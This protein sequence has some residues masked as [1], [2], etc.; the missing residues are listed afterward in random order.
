MSYKQLPANA[1]ERGAALQAPIWDWTNGIKLT[2]GATQVVS[3]AISSNC[4]LLVCSNNCFIKV[5]AAPVAADAADSFRLHADTIL[6]IGFVEGEKV[7]VIQAT[8]E[9]SL[10]ILPRL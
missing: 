5:A 1:A 8:G 4:I 7:S 10:Y 6:A 2:A 3:T 9:G